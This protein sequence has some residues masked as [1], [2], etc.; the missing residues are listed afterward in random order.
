[1]FLAVQF[2][3][4]YGLISDS[5]DLLTGMYSDDRGDDSI[6][7]GMKYSRRGTETRF[8]SVHS[9][10]RRSS[11]PCWCFGGLVTA[12]VSIP[13]GDLSLLASLL[14]S[15]SSSSSVGGVGVPKRQYFFKKE[16]FKEM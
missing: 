5:D 13:G 3:G 11:T 4:D 12:I 6:E 8:S 9:T 15:A 10:R 2:R 14:T 1:V 7:E 16:E